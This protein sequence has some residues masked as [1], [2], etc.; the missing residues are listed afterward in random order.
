MIIRPNFTSRLKIYSARLR[1]ISSPSLGNRHL[2]LVL[3]ARLQLFVLSVHRRVCLSVYFQLELPMLYTH[4][5][6]FSKEMLFASLLLQRVAVVEFWLK[7]DLDSNSSFSFWRLVG[8]ESVVYC[9]LA[10]ND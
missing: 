9:F 2:F 10:L 8:L 5:L 3:C 4:L 6:L 1:A 7:K